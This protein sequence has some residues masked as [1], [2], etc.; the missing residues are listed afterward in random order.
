MNSC[1]FIGNLAADPEIKY[2]PSGEAVANITVACSE[3]WKSKDGTPQEHTEF[4]RGSAFGKLA[5]IMSQ[6]LNKGDK[7]FV[8][9]KLNTRKWEDKDGNNRYST[10]IKFRELEMLG[11]GNKSGG[12]KSAAPAQKGNQGSMDFQSQD[13]P[14]FDDD[15]PF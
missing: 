1:S 8:S 11:S 4:V 2:L 14:A 3:K 7:V 9:G 13:K 15:I 5:E 10:E 12:A 6:Y